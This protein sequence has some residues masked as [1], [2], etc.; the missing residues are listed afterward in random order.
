MKTHLW[1]NP[2]SLTL[3][4]AIHFFFFLNP[5]WIIHFTELIF[6]RNLIIPHADKLSHMIFAFTA[7]AGLGTFPVSKAE[8]TPCRQQI[9]S[10]AGSIM[11]VQSQTKDSRDLLPECQTSTK[12]DCTHNTCS[13]RLYL[14]TPDCLWSLQMYVLILWG[15]FPQTL[16]Q[17]YKRLNYLK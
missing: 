7:I 1:G 2:L 9:A 8:N 15:S 16:K 14:I 4:Y 11:A 6:Q 13:L 5:Y 3:L 17:V 12:T 10:P